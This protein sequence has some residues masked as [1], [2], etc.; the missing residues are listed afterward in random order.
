[1]IQKGFI[2]SQGGELLGNMTDL[3]SFSC[4]FTR[5]L[6]VLQLRQDVLSGKYVPIFLFIFLEPESRFSGG[7]A[8]SKVYQLKA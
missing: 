8:Q 2:V 5:Y 3:C 7:D 6:F 4:V 1:M